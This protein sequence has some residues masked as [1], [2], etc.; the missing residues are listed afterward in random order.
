[1]TCRVTLGVMRLPDVPPNN[2]FR[3]LVAEDSSSVAQLVAIHLKMAGFDVFLAPDGTE[4]W[5]HFAQIDPHLLLTDVYMPGLSGHELT[6][7]VRGV[8][9]IPI[10]MMTGEDTDETQIRGL[11][12]GADDYI[13]KPL[14]LKVL[15]ARVIAH[16]RRV[17]RYDFSP[18]PVHS[19]VEEKPPLP[20]GFV[21]CEPCGYLGPSWKFQAQNAEGREISRC[22]HC[23]NHVVTFSVS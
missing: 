20:V 22:P 21:R 11:K 15:T 4:A 23:G 17:Y 16:L 9:G 19:S 18:P 13:P 14:H 1:V 8:S 3:I 6:E 2:R 7:K 10:L 5:C 12:V